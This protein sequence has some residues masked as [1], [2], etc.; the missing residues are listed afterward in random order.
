MFGYV[1]AGFL[2]SE[3]YRVGFYLAYQYLK[4]LGDFRGVASLTTPVA[5]PWLST[6]CNSS[7]RAD[8]GVD[9]FGEGTCGV[10]GVRSKRVLLFFRGV[11]G[12]GGCKRGGVIYRGM[13][14]E[15]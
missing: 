1:A 10:S 8:V 12:V 15:L 2:E 7:L 3:S 11:R 5:L 4:K 6:S 13:Y 14:P 9:R